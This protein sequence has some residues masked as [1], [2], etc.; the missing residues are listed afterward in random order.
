MTWALTRGI[1]AAA[2]NVAV[3]VVELGRIIV[4]VDVGHD[5]DDDVGGVS[6]GSH[7]DNVPCGWCVDDVDGALTTW[8]LST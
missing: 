3:I 5:D 6:S 4:V 8:P 7:V 1:D 2:V